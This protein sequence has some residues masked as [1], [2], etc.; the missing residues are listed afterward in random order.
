MTTKPHWLRDAVTDD[1]GDFD[2]A[3]MGVAVV[4]AMTVGAVTV[5]CVALLLGKDPQPLGVAV[6]AIFA[7]FATALGALGVYRWG[8]RR[9]PP[10]PGGD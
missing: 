3:N 9:A 8:D 10:P 5:A 4:I 7:G 1:R 2:V 6:G